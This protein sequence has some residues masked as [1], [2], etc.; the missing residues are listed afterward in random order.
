[1]LFTVVEKLAIDVL[2]STAFIDKYILAILAA[3][4][5]VGVQ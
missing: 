3:E 4:R 1:M 2:I 5:K